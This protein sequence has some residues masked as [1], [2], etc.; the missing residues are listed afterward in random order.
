MI[1]RCQ[2]VDFPTILEI[3]NDSAEAYRGIIP[4][5]RWQD[6]YM[7][8]NELKDQIH[9]GVE[10]YCYKED[11]KITGVMGIQLKGDVTLIRHAYVRTKERNKGIGKK[12]LTYLNGITT[13]PILIGTW[14]DATWAIEFYRKTGFRLLSNETKNNLLDKYWKIPNRQRETSVVLASPDWNVAIKV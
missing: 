2:E 5:D 6:P 12:L 9:D 3:I 7:S 4:A 1:T 8:D 13:T 14:E 10:F 11:D